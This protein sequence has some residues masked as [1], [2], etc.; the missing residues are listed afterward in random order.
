MPQILDDDDDEDDEVDDVTLPP[1]QHAEAASD[2]PAAPGTEPVVEAV[3]EE[4]MP[5][6]NP[7]AESGG[8]FSSMLGGSDAPAIEPAA[9]PAAMAADESAVEAKVV[10]TATPDETASSIEPSM[11]PVAGTVEL[12]VETEVTHQEEKE[13]EEEEEEKATEKVTAAE[14]VDPLPPPPPPPPL[15]LDDEPVADAEPL[16]SPMPMPAPDPVPFPL[17]PEESAAFDLRLWLRSRDA[18]QHTELIIESFVDAEYPPSEWVA[19]LRAFHDDE[20]AGFLET[21]ASVGAADDLPADLPEE[22]PAGLPAGLSAELP[23]TEEKKSHQLAE[24]T[25]VEEVAV[26]VAEEQGAPSA[27]ELERQEE[28]VAAIDEKDLS[29]D[30]RTDDGADAKAVDDPPETQAEAPPPEVELCASNPCHNGGKCSEAL[31]VLWCDCTDGFRGEVCA[32]DADECASRPCRNGATC[33]ESSTK[34]ADVAHGE[35]ACVCAIGWQGLYCEHDIDECQSAP[36][37]NGGVCSHHVDAYSCECPAGFVDHDCET[38]RDECESTPCSTRGTCAEVTPPADG[39]FYQCTCVLGFVGENCGVNVDD[40]ASLPCQNGGTCVDQ[41][42]NYTCLCADGFADSEAGHPSCSQHVPCASS[43]CH[44]GGQCASVASAASAP[45]LEYTCSCLSG[46]E[47]SHCDTDLDECVSSPCQNGAVCT[48]APGAFVCNCTSGYDGP[49]CADDADECASQ[50]CLNGG[51]C[52][53][54]PFYITASG[55]KPV[56]PYYSCACSD[57]FVGVNCRVDV[58]ECE[59]APCQNGGECVQ[60]LF[61]RAGGRLARFSCNC[62][63]G[64]AGELCERDVN[65]CISAP[66]VNGGTCSE[67]TSDAT[68]STGSLKCACLAGFAGATCADDVD[69][70]ASNPCKNE[71]ACVEARAPRFFRCLCREGFTGDICEA[72]VVQAGVCASQ[73]CLNGGIC[74]DSDSAPGV[75]AQ[76]MFLCDCSPTDGFAGLLCDAAAPAVAEATPRQK[77]AEEPAGNQTA[78]SRISEETEQA[79]QEKETTAVEIAREAALKHFLAQQA[80]KV[81]AATANVSVGMAKAEEHPSPAAAAAEALPAEAVPVSPPAVAD[82]ELSLLETAQEDAVLDS[83]EEVPDA[84]ALEAAAV[85]PRGDFPDEEA[86]PAVSA[87]ATEPEE[88]P[89]PVRAST[90]EPEAPSSPVLKPV[91]IPRPAPIK[92]A[93]R[94]KV[95]K[96]AP[97]PAEEAPGNEVFNGQSMVFLDVRQIGDLKLVKLHNPVCGF[98]PQCGEWRGD[99]SDNSTK[100]Q[101]H[102]RVKA[103]LKPK[104]QPDGVFWMSFGEYQ[105]RF[106]GTASRKAGGAHR[107]R[108][109]DHVGGRPIQRNGRPTNLDTADDKQSQ[110]GSAKEETAP[111]AA[112]FL[113]D[114]RQHFDGGVGYAYFLRLLKLYST[115]NQTA[116]EVHLVVQQLF[117]GSSQLQR[118]FNSL[119]PPPKKPAAGADNQKSA[120]GNEGEAASA[121]DEED[122]F[123]LDELPEEVSGKPEAVGLIDPID[124]EQA[125]AEEFRQKE[126]ERKAAEAEAKA[127]DPCSSTPCVAGSTCRS[128]NETAAGFEC[129]CAAG[130][131]GVHCEVAECPPGYWESAKGGRACAPLSVCN[132]TIQ[133]EEIAANK[134]QDRL[135]LAIRSS[136]DDEIEFEAAAPTNTSN[137]VCESATECVGDSEYEASPLEAGADRVCKEVR[138]A[139]VEGAEWEALGPTTHRDRECRAVTDCGDD[140]LEAGP[141]GATSDRLCHGLHEAAAAGSPSLV[142]QLLSKSGSAVDVNAQ[143]EYGH[144]ALHEVA[145]VSADAV[146]SQDRLAVVDMLLD[147]GADVTLQNKKGHTALHIAADVGNADAVSALLKRA[148]SIDVNAADAGGNTPLHFAAEM[149]HAAAAEVLIESGATVGPLNADGR[150]PAQLTDAI[151]WHDEKHGEIVRVLKRYGGELRRGLRF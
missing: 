71:G 25:V 105:A 123:E 34:G 120:T 38:D 70:C 90:A 1:P 140:Q 147:G 141:P 53:Q 28:T 9:E 138:G 30:E 137:R 41:V 47:G 50:P 14:L 149:G 151:K 54:T 24:A 13:E 134:S 148:R 150:T 5:V 77:A 18:E 75:V 144:T 112:E 52:T 29:Q 85:A 81:S 127:K 110:D 64:L 39:L 68:V 7:S 35:Y 93:R 86:P 23:E 98:D 111:S 126:T 97:L 26:A 59:S 19:T 36:C 6:E 87:E 128:D 99:W 74:E 58:N 72:S 67:S 143:N 130:Y 44:N 115:G 78:P 31:G 15:L 20:L 116:A 91:M 69:E 92:A 132:L 43:P 65:E 22:L 11:E 103:M 102:P 61:Q 145:G 118:G 33:E 83:A 56:A 88:P 82:E 12:E 114:V 57:G 131:T 17:D 10:E 3:K 37:H 124:V 51:T 8:W 146:P 125:K 96:I 62:M 133:Y 55:A 100:W 113:A 60:G 4:D 49:V 32:D 106:H 104:V 136:C 108:G 16:P 89:A 27:G 76:G 142:A 2:P 84:A 139:C 63:A 42:G 101:H 48:D 45:L 80:A 117:A 107:A 73:P 66:C 129:A 109:G 94:A 135:C 119:V 79:V 21:V 95:R 122:S 46:F 40:C 121:E